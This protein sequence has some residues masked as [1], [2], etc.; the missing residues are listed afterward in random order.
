V[1]TVWLALTPANAENGCLHFQ[2]SSHLQQMP[3]VDTHAEG[4]LLLKG[5]TIQA[6]HGIDVRA[7]CWAICPL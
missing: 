2:P 7:A 1:A 3:H 5:Q 6:R 4:N